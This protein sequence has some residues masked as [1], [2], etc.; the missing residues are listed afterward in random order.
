MAVRKLV[1]SNLLS[2][3]ARAALTVAA[4][5][6]AV[7]LVVSVTSGYASIEAAVYKYLNQYLGSVDAEIVRANDPAVGTP[8]TLLQQLRADPDVESADGRYETHG[9]LLTLDGEPMPNRV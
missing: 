4:V 3:K 8:E 9:T 7:S 2:R 1:V 5:A 6:L